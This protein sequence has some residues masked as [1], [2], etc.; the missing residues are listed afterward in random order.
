MYVFRRCITISFVE[1]FLKTGMDSMQAATAPGAFHNS[2]E[3]CDPPKCHPHTREAIL[4][5]IFDWAKGEIDVEIFILWLWGAAGAGK[6]AIAQSLAELCE[7]QNLL[8][9]SFFFSR[10]APYRGT[11]LH[12]FASLAYQIV[13]AIPEIGGLVGSAVERD[14][15]IF[16]QSLET[17][18]A[19]L[20]AYPLRHFLEQNSTEQLLLPRLIIIDGLDECNDGT[21]RQI[22]D[23]VLKVTRRFS[24]PLLFL[25]AS[26]PEQDISSF[27]NMPHVREVSTRIALDTE[28]GSNG[29]IERFLRDKISVIRN[30]HPLRSTLPPSWP[31]EED[32]H[33]LMRKSSGQFIYAATAV[34]YFSSPRHR[35]T[36]RL[37]VILGVIRP[38][39]SE[40]PFAELDAL[41]RHIV[42]ST[43]DFQLTVRILMTLTLIGGAFPVALDHLLSFEP[44]DS[45]LRLAELGALVCMDDE[46]VE[47]W[48]VRFFFRILHASL[49][50]FLADPTR[51]GALYVDP[52]LVHADIARTCIRFLQQSHFP[53]E[54]IY[55]FYTPMLIPNAKISLSML[56]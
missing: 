11:S 4:Q 27:F 31:S 8:L 51:S 18:Y 29:D 34:K 10:N 30:T 54:T 44:G 39:P 20:I 53:G 49:G 2:R 12:L 33:T 25:V 5:K 43:D 22:L 17:Q 52:G 41:Y 9:G 38:G 23:V 37:N 32:I 40:L 15:L 55:I 6:S 28:Y 19:T 24:L 56:L 45:M 46:E 3:R 48:E 36:Q 14:P 7:E 1:S 47:I 13:R 26:R 42:Y 16:H 21:Q 35:P 50:D